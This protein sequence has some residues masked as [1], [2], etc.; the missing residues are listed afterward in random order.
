MDFI[1]FEQINSPKEMTMT[2]PHSHEFYELYF[3]LEGK[4]NFFIGNKMFVVEKN[5]LVVLPPFSLHKTEGGAYK[6]IN[7]NVSTSLLSENQQKFLRNIS[8]KPAIKIGTTYSEI[9]KRLLIEGAKLEDLHRED[10]LLNLSSILNTILLLLSTQDTVSLAAVSTAFTPEIVPSDVLKIIYHINTHFEEK[11]TLDSLSEQFYLS[12][13]SICKK[14]KDVMNCSIMD[15][16]N[17]LRLNKAK[18]L[19]RDSK[20]S[21][22]EIADA[23]GFSSANYLGLVFKKEM[24][25]SPLNYRKTR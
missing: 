6:R 8:S 11:I 1:E 2:H 20:L 24:G 25:I 16:V 5:T 21:M 9:I 19:L 13:V 12:R 3:L 10:K 15:Y 17:G 4:R 14:F 7:I 18:S 23:C 22:E